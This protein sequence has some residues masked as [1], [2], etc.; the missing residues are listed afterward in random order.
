VVINQYY[1]TAI[2]EFSTTNP[3][4]INPS[5]SLKKKGIGTWLTSER[6]RGLSTNYIDRFLTLLQKDGRSGK[7]IKEVSKSSERILGKLGDPT[8]D[9]TF[10]VKGLVVGEIQSGKTG[11]FNAVI[12]R[13]I[14]SGYSLIIVLSGIIEDLRRQTQLRIENDVVGEGTIDIKRSIKGDK[15]VGTIKKVAREYLKCL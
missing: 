9:R 15:G 8:S 14:D 13:A 1:K 3:V 5:C 4:Y 2:D 10:Y 6:K 11:N 7:V 12:N